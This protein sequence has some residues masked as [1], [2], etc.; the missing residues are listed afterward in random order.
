ML[1]KSNDYYFATADEIKSL[2]V[3]GKRKKLQDYIAD[4]SEKI[5]QETEYGLENKGKSKE[6]FSVDLQN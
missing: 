1:K 3:D 5:L 6:I 4:H 2:G